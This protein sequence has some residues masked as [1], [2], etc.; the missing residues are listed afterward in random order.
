M[1]IQNV[2]ETIAT[3]IA[4]KYP[5]IQSLLSAYDNPSLSIKEKIDLLQNIEIEGR[6]TKVGPMLSSKI[7]L[8]FNETDGSKLVN[9]KFSK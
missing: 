3:A 6:K 2:S 1:Q 7:Y 9:E 4:K 5:S 8:I